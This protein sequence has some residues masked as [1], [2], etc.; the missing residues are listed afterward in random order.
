MKR[1]LSIRILMIILAV[2]LLGTSAGCVEALFVTHAGALGLGW[3]LGSVNA[4]TTV[5]RECFLNGE[6]VDCATLPDDLQP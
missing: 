6:L 2:L 3:L 1:P 4:P 5:D